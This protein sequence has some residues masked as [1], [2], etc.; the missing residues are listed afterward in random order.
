MFAVRGKSN[1]SIKTVA[2]TRQAP[3]TRHAVTRHPSPQLRATPAG[4]VTGARLKFK[5]SPFSTNSSVA[6]G[7][8]IRE[9]HE[10]I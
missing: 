9:I 6:H 2:V 4:R 1:P 5:Q 7:V 3:V 10:K 8:T